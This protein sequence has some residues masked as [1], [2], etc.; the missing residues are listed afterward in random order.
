MPATLQ[1]MRAA[2]MAKA[3]VNSIIG[4]LGENITLMR[5]ITTQRKS[6]TPTPDAEDS[7]LKQ[8][9]DG[10]DFANER[11]DQETALMAPQVV[12]GVRSKIKEA[13]EAL[14]AEGV[15]F[16]LPEAVTSEMMLLI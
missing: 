5:A 3:A 13:L 12:R 9:L 6:L 2:A 11:E 14:D 7:A 4:N 8:G 16:E 1:G 10:F 15:T